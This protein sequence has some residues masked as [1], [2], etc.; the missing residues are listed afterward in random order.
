MSAFSTLL[1]DHLWIPASR[2]VPRSRQKVMIVLHGRGDSALAFSNIKNE[3][4]LPNVNYLVINAPRKY[5]TGFTWCALDPKPGSP[6]LIAIRARLFALIEE[7]KVYGWKPSE[8]LWLGHSQGCLVAT[9]VALNHRE[10]FAGLIGVSGYVS[11]QPGWK[12]KLAR[13]KAAKTPWLMTHGTLDRVIRLD[14]F[15]TDVRRLTS[16]AVRLETA[17]FIKGHDF[18]FK[19]EVPFI[20][21]WISNGI[22]SASRDLP[23]SN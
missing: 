21:R 15:R 5:E 13:S 2:A 23:D 8:L 14:E 7:L 20:R 9:D 19:N 22:T 3:L 18:D 16:G 12:S 1:F 17:E 10:T 4:R 6:S 11:L